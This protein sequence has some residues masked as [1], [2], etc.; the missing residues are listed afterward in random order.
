M[1]DHFKQSYVYLFNVFASSN[2]FASSN[3]STP[4][5]SVVTHL[6]FWSAIWQLNYWSAKALTFDTVT[7][8]SYSQNVTIHLQNST[9]DTVDKNYKLEKAWVTLGYKDSTNK[10]MNVSYEMLRFLS[11]PGKIIKSNCNGEVFLDKR[12]NGLDSQA[13]IK[14]N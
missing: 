9:M 11:S 10:K 13:W 5:I 1:H 12:K 2:F 8:I 3:W 7:W 6:F 14:I 4:F